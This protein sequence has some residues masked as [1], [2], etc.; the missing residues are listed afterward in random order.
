M[1]LD[2]CDRC[3]SGS[4]INAVLD[5]SALNMDHRLR[6]SAMQHFP[7]WKHLKLHR[8]SNLMQQILCEIDIKLNV[9][10]LHHIEMLW[11]YSSLSTHLDFPT[12]D[13]HEVWLPLKSIL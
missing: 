4:P 3:F 9:I 11:S 7:V 8:N 12:L 13:E 10:S 5:I 6:T 2:Y 1:K